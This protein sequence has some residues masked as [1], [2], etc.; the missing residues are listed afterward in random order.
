M[1]EDTIKSTQGRT[2][3]MGDGSQICCHDD[4]CIYAMAERSGQFWNL[5]S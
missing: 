1:N 3:I 2:C 5:S 4:S